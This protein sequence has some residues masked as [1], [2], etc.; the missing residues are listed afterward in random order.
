MT[1]TT[2]VLLVLACLVL[3]GW[4]TTG[5]GGGIPR[6]PRRAASIDRAGAPD[7]VVTGIRRQAGRLRDHLAEAR[8]LQPVRR[9]PFRFVASAGTGP[10]SRREPAPAPL[11]RPARP[12]MKLSGIGEDVVDGATVRTAVISA[13]NQLFMVREGE[14]VLSRYVVARIGADA[15]VLRDGGDGEPF[16]LTLR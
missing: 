5:V 6:E 10:V 15:V 12:D 14:R 7:P 11:E 9:D 13:M 4:L 3:A 16:T 1:R 2:G 8:P